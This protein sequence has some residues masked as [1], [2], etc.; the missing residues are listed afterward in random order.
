MST[1]AAA[2]TAKRQAAS[3]ASR[4]RVGS[5]V[6]AA[7]GKASG[8]LSDGAH[9]RLVEDDGIDPSYKVQSL[10]GG[11]ASWHSAFDVVLADSSVPV[12]SF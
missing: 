9:G 11:S 5:I 8:V 3:V 7:P 1:H 12:R 6:R 10:R 4:I 2:F